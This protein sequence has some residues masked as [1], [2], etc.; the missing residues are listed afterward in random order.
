MNDCASPQDLTLAT[1]GEWTL[2][3]TARD[4]SGNV[5]PAATSTYTY[6]PP[7]PV[8]TSV[9]AP[10]AGADS[11]PTWTFIVPRGYTASCLV[12]DAGGTTV[13][14]ADCTRGSFTPSLVGLAEGTYTQYRSV[15]TTPV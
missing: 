11:T 12:S 4:A 5:S 1:P 3:V 8:V 14:R 7:V 2:S 9:R 15:R 10:V 13:A 6:L